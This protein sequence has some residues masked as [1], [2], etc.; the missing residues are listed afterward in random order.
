MATI[1]GEIAARL[2]PQRGAVVR[3]NLA[4]VVG[5]LPPREMDRLVRRAFVEYAR[6]WMLGARLAGALVRDRTRDV[7]I[8]GR[9]HIVEA[10]ATGGVIFAVPHIGQWDAGGLVSVIEGFPIATVAEEASS[11][12]L[13]AWFTRQR[14]RLGLISY[15][16]GSATTSTLIDFLRNGGAVALVADRDVVGDGI[17]LPFFGATTSIPTGPVVLALRSGATILPSAVYLR[18]K[19]RIE[20][21]I[22][23]PLPLERRGR[24]RDDVARLTADLVR[25]YEELIRSAPE[26]WHVFQPIWPEDAH[27]L[28]ASVT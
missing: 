12:E 6:Y 10:R 15:P 18:P 13:T 2:L 5:P 21:A 24:L 16:P 7:T 1:G 19:G 14:A 27:P 17:V 20:V 3:A 11:P 25:R 23:R 9:E 4:R 22:G 8:T 28:S 26:Q